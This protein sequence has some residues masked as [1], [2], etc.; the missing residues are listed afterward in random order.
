[1]SAPQH[2]GD[3]VLPSQSEHFEIWTLMPFS[4]TKVTLTKG[5]SHLAQEAFTAIPQD[6]HSS[7]AIF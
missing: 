3:L 5:I 1:M 6:K 4:V 2:I 7:V